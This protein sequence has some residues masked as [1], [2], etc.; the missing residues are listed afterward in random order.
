MVGGGLLG[1]DGSVSDIAF[2]ACDS[3]IRGHRAGELF[4]FSVLGKTKPTK[5]IAGVVQRMLPG[6]G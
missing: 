4:P 1:R 2:T 6:H 5:G 3:S